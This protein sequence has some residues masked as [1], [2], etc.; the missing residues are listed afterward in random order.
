MD[1]NQTPYS[2]YQGLD[3]AC[4]PR[5]LLMTCEEVAQSSIPSISYKGPTIRVQVHKHGELFHDISALTSFTAQIPTP[6]SAHVRS[7]LSTCRCT[8]PQDTDLTREGAALGPQYLEA[9]HRHTVS[10]PPAAQHTLVSHQGGH[11]AQREGDHL[12]T[13]SESW[14][15]WSSC[16]AR[17]EGPS[18]S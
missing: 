13:C 17:R 1:P 10:A 5:L 15:L 12:K 4:M 6:I 2:A 8:A 18:N 14:G 3:A 7:F 11:R 9:H 16:P